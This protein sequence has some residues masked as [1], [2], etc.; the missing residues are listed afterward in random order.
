MIGFVFVDGVCEERTKFLKR[1]TGLVRLHSSVFIAKTRRSVNKPHPQGIEYAWIW[2]T[3]LLNLGMIIAK[4]KVF[5]ECVFIFESYRSRCGCECHHVAWIYSN[6]WRR[7][8]E[9][10]WSAIRES[11]AINSKSIYHGA[12]QNWYRRLVSTFVPHAM[13]SFEQYLKQTIKK[14]LFYTKLTAIPM[15]QY[16]VRNFFLGP[17]VRLQGLITKILSERKIDPPKEL[18]PAN[19]W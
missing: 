1:L 8:V 10:I 7:I 12:K 14:F 19:F 18:L 6:R 4:E 13:S 17:T 16:N 3:N 5:F 11:A 9:H 15:R 2:L